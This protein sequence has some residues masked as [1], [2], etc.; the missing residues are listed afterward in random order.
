MKYPAHI[1]KHSYL[2]PFSLSP[3]VNT[4]VSVD[5]ITFDDLRRISE[6]SG[7]LVLGRVGASGGAESRKSCSSGK[8]GG[9]VVE[10]LCGASGFVMFIEKQIKDVAGYRRRDH[11]FTP[12]PSHAT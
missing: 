3:I 5:G 11:S 4:S 10:T 12:T 2:S 7:K 9:E 8:E 1:T 6:E